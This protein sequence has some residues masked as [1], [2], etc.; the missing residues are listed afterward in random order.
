MLRGTR[1]SADGEMATGKSSVMASRGLESL[2]FCS[3]E[4]WMGSLRERD[5][6]G[7]GRNYGLALWRRPCLNSRSLRVISFVLLYLTDGMPLR[8]A[9]ETREHM[10]MHFS[11]SSVYAPLFTRRLIAHAPLSPSELSNL[12]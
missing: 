2:G 10:G 11:H 8:A 7:N 1:R 4:A 9:F 3:G 5:E 12:L 6:G